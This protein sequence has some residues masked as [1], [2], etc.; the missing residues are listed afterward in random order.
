MASL[1]VFSCPSRKSP[2]GEP[3]NGIQRSAD[4]PSGFLHR[5]QQRVLVEPRILV[6][7]RHLR[8]SDFAREDPANAA[9]GSEEHTSELQSLMRI[10]YAVFCLIKKTTTYTHTMHKTP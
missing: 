7:L 1:W 9:A 4:A 3:R 6:D 10:S 5:A 2:R 8:F